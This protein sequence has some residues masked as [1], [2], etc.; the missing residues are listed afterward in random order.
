MRGWRAV[1]GGLDLARTGATAGRHDV[2]SG[3]DAAGGHDAVSSHD[4][5]GRRAFAWGRAVLTALSLLAIGAAGSRA[6]EPLPATPLPPVQV[7]YLERCGGCHGIQ[8]HSAPRE[9]PRLRGQV[10]YFL[11]LPDARAYLVRLPSV[12]TSPLSD[13]ELAALL[14]FVVFDLGGAPAKRAVATPYTPEEVG[15]LRKQPLNEVS[16]A[17]YREAI[18]TRLIDQCGAPSSLREYVS[19]RSN[20]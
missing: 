4:T 17:G 13:E 14:N 6:A 9:V 10:G 1:V 2:A 15:V 19:A 8:G 12:A 5:A 16:L 18:V 20:P 11:C 3:H 7:T